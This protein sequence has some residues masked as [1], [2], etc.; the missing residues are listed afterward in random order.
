M[1]KFRNNEAGFSVIELVLAL[2][3]VVLIG[4]SGWLIY[5]DHHKSTTT[6][7]KSTSV[8]TTSNPYAGW[9]TYTFSKEKLSFRY[10]TTW[11]ANS[12]L[13]N[14]SNDGVTF[15]SSDNS[16]FEIEIGAGPSIEAGEYDSN[17]VVQ[18]DP[19]TFD[20]QK[21]YLDMIGY[22]T[23]N[24]PPTD[25]VPVGDITSSNTVTQVL[26]SSSSSSVNYFNAKNIS[27][28]SVILE[29]DFWG[30]NGSN[31][32]VSNNTTISYIENDADY[33]DVKLVVDSMIY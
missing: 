1:K 22:A 19:V 6:T 31:N 3:I 21:A 18:A 12:N 13:T 4:I 26:L 11:A 14:S 2:A 8:S 9:N 29:M 16:Y 27:N 23:N 25:C 7:T 30:P 28:S 32:S 20:G 5:R 24:F 33:K 15:T 10:P 17:C